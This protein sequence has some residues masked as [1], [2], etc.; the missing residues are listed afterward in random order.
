MMASNLTLQATFMDTNRP[1]VSITNLVSGQRVSNAVITVSGKAADNWQ[2]TGVNVQA[3]YGGW[4]SAVGTNN[5][6]ARLNLTAG[7]NLVQAYAVDNSGNV[8][9]TNTIKINYVPS[10]P[11]TVQ[12]VG[13]GSVTPN[14]NGACLAIGSTYMMTATASNGFAFY[15]W[16]GGVT[17]TTNKTLTF[18]MSSNL[19]ITANFRDVTKPAMPAITFP[20]ANQKWSNA[21]I[22]VTGKASDNVGVTDV[23]VQINNGGWVAAGTINGFANWTATNLPVSFGTNII[24]AYA[25]DAA[26]NVS[27]TNVVRFVAN[28]VPGPN[29]VLIPAGSFTMGTD[30]E[31]AWWE[32]HPTHTVNLSAFYMEK[33]DVTYE[34]W[35]Q[36]FNWAVAHG[37][38][39]NYAGTG[40][41]ANHPVLRVDWFDCVAW[42]NARSEMEGRVPAYYTD[43]TQTKVVRW[44][45]DCGYLTNDCVK[46]H[47]GYRLPTEAEWEYAARGGLSGQRFPW[48]NTIS[49][50]Q[51]NYR[52]DIPGYVPAYDLGTGWGF[53]PAFTNGVWPYTSPVD[54]FAPNGYGL[55]DMAGNVNQWCWDQWGD[56]SSASQTDPHGPSFDPTYAERMY[57]GGAF[58]WYGQACWTA[59]RSSSSPGMNN[60][61]VGLRC[62]LPAGQ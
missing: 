25:M 61:D 31:P 12:I 20:V 50:S 23:G 9:L 21:T 47:S 56:Y 55:Y 42:C 5:W 19:S 43:A 27:P 22:T 51:A 24:Q 45:S 11:L 30:D 59:I 8:S 34:L 46:W 28:G 53:N 13:A 26:G 15:Y 18:T 44:T 17:M 60:G 49:W 7:T 29:M 10:S 48:G 37:Y 39:F 2:V 14:Y 16:G 3:N 57:R 40:K 62:V 54:Y 6:S 1:T 38:A 32:D 36:V 35:Q 33:Y 58:D 52:R 4:T 41:A